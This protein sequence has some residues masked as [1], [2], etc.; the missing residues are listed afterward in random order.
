[1]VQAAGN[2]MGTTYSVKVVGGDGKLPTA[3]ALSELADDTFAAI[4][5]SMSTYISDSELSQL[6]R[7]DTSS[8][9]PISQPLFEVLEL[10]QQVSRKSDGAFDITVMPLV[11]LWG[12]GPAERGAEPSGEQI[13][14]VLQQ[15]GYQKVQL[16]RSQTAVQRPA[17][18]TIDLSAI[19]KGYA[20]DVLAAELR[21]QGHNHFMVE[22]GGE[23]VLA[24]NNPRG[25]PW[26]IGIETP[27]YQLLS[28]PQGPV[29]AV[30]LSGVGMATSGDYRNYY[31]VDGARLS[32]TLDPKTGRP[33]T[34]RLAS[35]T[36]IAPTAAAADA[37]ATALNV[38]G[39]D[40]A[41]AVAEREQLAVFLLVRTGDGFEARQSTAFGPYLVN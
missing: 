27:N 6:N 33:I 12:F 23:L 20:A 3:E 5:R 29:K 37:W 30:D 16:D 10:S 21:A 32:H 15:I 18:V 35:V 34:H 13:A 25:K 40:K 24:G 1:M 36:V 28:A 7:A 31:E 11:D 39:P 14:R 9:Q 8:W 2:T 41:L 4:N 26:R 22:V 17:G 38:L 19:A